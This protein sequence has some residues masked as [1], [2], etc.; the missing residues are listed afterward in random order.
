MLSARSCVAFFCIALA[1]TL[2]HAGMPTVVYD[3]TQTPTSGS[4]TPDGFWAFSNWMPNEPTGQTLTLAGTDRFVT[5]FDL[6]FSSVV[7]TKINSLSF[8][9]HD[10]SGLDRWNHPGAPSEVPL[11]SMSVQDIWIEG[12]TVVTFHPNV[13]VPERLIWVISADSLDAGPATYGP[14]IVGSCPDAF[15]DYDYSG[16]KKWATY[17]FE[18]DPAAQFGAKV[19]AV[20]EPSTLA[21]MVLG[22]MWAGRRRARACMR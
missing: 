22:G 12:P 20:P 11:W 18:H 2:A 8:S 10:T 14:P 9:L 13:T 21:I 3:N 7:R 5:Q 16:I 15:W 19:F 17:N 6:V 4:W 1:G